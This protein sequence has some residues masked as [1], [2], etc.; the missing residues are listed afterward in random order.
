MH[1]LKF[2]NKDSKRGDSIR[3]KGGIVFIKKTKI[4]AATIE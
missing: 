2:K 1:R 4:E 3:K